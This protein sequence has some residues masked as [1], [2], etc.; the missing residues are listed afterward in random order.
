MNP[1]TPL[2]TAVSRK[3]VA[4]TI[5]AL[6]WFAPTMRF[7]FGV[8]VVAGAWPLVVGL[9]TAVCSVVVMC[10]SSFIVAVCLIELIRSLVAIV[11]SSF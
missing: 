6:R 1:A 5:S 3:R 9:C 11:F 7:D 4:I 8:C 10:V 2:V